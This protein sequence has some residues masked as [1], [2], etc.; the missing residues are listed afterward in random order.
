VLY[1]LATLLGAP[2]PTY[3]FPSLFASI[4]PATLP[5]V[6]V[7]YLGH[8]VAGAVVGLLA[9]ACVNISSKLA[10]ASGYPCAWDHFVRKCVP[11][12]M[13]AVTLQ[14]GD[15][16]VGFLKTCDAAVEQKERDLVL[17]EPAVYIEEQRDYLALSYQ[18]LFI[19][20]SLMYSIAV[21]YDPD[22]DARIVQTGQSPF[23]G[24]EET[25]EQS[26]E[27]ATAQTNTTP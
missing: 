5:I 12:H 3:I 11:N 2:S 14:N 23:R 15:V 8:C 17:S 4:S 25:H 19:P 10:G 16:Y 27:A 13:V 6:A 20:A 7:A 1:S 18:Q 24:K 9:A 21:I 22:R 26:A